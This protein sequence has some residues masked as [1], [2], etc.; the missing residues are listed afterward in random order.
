MACDWQHQVSRQRRECHQ[1]FP[2]IPP[3]DGR[4]CWYQRCQQQGLNQERLHGEFLVR[5]GAQVPVRVPASVTFS[6]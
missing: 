4:V 1:E 5:G 6:S 3:G 2:N